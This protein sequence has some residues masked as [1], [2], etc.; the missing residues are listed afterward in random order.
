M[1]K[2]YVLRHLWFRYCFTETMKY[3]HMCCN[4][5]ALIRPVSGNKSMNLSNFLQFAQDFCSV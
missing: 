3:K 5:S 2:Q 1:V 4:T